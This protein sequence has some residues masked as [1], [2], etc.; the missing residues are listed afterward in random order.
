MAV[1]SP[2]VSPQAAVSRSSRAENRQIA[3]FMKVPPQSQHPPAGVGV[4]IIVPNLSRVVNERLCEKT[5]F[6][7]KRPVR[8]DLPGFLSPFSEKCCRDMTLAIS[9]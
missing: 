3:R 2:V 6:S 1:G 5:S 7:G 4:S 9:T 8:P